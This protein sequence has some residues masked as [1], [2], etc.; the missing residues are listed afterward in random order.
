MN[1]CVCMCVCVCVYVKEREFEF[2][3]KLQKSTYPILLY[4]SS[5][6]TMIVCDVYYQAARWMTEVEVLLSFYDFLRF[7]SIFFY[8]IRSVSLFL[9]Q[10]KNYSS[11]TD[12]TM[13]GRLMKL[14]KMVTVCE[15]IFQTCIPR[16][17]IF[18]KPKINFVKLH[19]LDEK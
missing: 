12:C 4:W 2:E 19:L 18:I 5:N 11:I 10:Y 3:K 16:Q 6:N 13:K 15:N 8:V 17:D 9:S 7:S 14:M 1:E